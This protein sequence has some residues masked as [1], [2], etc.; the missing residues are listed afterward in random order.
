MDLKRDWRA[1]KFCI[2][3]SNIQIKDFL[4]LKFN[5]KKKE[6]DLIFSFKPKE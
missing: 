6:R 3:R 1:H 5:I 4:I 2:L